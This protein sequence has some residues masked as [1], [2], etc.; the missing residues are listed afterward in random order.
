MLSYD[1]VRARISSLPLGT[2]LEVR[3]HYD[4]D[5]EVRT[6]FGMLDRILHDGEQLFVLSVSC[7]RRKS[8]ATPFFQNGIVYDLV[9]AVPKSHS[10]D[11]DDDDGLRPPARRQPPADDDFAPRPLPAAP[12]ALAPSASSPAAVDAALLASIVAA[13]VAAIR[14]SDSH[15][16]PPQ[17]PTPTPPP[18]VHFVQ[19]MPDAQSMW[20]M[21]QAHRNEYR[22]FWDVCPGLAMLLSPADV[23]RPFC[24]PHY[25]CVPRGTTGFSVPSG[26]AADVLGRW[27]SDRQKAERL[28]TAFPHSKEGARDPGA[29]VRRATALTVAGAEQAF[30]ALLLRYAG[31]P[32]TSK[33]EWWPLFFTAMLLMQ[34]AATQA[35]FAFAVGAAKVAEGFDA[36]WRSGFVDPEK[37]WPGFPSA[38]A[39]K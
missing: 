12:A 35:G 18:T 17:P 39:P 4:D 30:E 1:D 37:I 8:E 32:P 20:A 28:I 9:R 34:H 21:S 27:R 26:P 33:D 36:A 23:V 5:P 38:S 22:P 25:L 15:A 3:F 14:S 13:T 29:A 16:Q 2:K 11:R 10:R 31:S 24:P 19:P 7:G 6:S